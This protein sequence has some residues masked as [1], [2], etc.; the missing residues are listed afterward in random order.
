MHTGGDFYCQG[1]D[2]LWLMVHLELAVMALTHCCEDLYDYSNTCFRLRGTG[3]V[4]PNLFHDNI[5]GRL[6]SRLVFRS[7]HL[8]VYPEFWPYCKQVNITHGMIFLCTWLT[9]RIQQTQG[10]TMSLL[11]LGLFLP[12]SMVFSLKLLTSVYL[13]GPAQALFTLRSLS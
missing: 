12:M 9:A 3:P 5:Q 2:D 7:V 13:Q 1:A 6:E 8:L 10:S 11:L 4:D